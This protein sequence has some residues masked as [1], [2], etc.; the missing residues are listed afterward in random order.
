MS[1]S[2]AL[3][4][5][6][7]EISARLHFS[8]GEAIPSVYYAAG[9]RL[10][11]PVA[12]AIAGWR[13]GVK[14]GLIVCITVG[15]VILSHVAAG[16]AVGTTSID[17]AVICVG[18][19]FGCLA[20]RQGEMNR[21][22]EGQARE[23]RERSEALAKEVAERKQIE[24]Q[25]IMTDR[26]ASIGELVSGVAHEVNNPL[27][28]V[29]GISQLMLQKDLPDDVREDIAAVLSEAERAARVVR[30]LLTFARKHPPANLPSHVNDIIEDTLRLR[31]Y[32]QKRHGVEVVRNLDPALP[33][34]MVDYHQMQQVFFNIIINAEYF[35]VQHHN[36]GTLTITTERADGHIRTLFA[37]D[38]PG[39]PEPNLPRVFE[40][41][42]TTKEVGKGTGLG[43]SI[44][45]G[46]VSAQ[47][48]RIYVQ[49]RPGKGA[50]FVVE[51]PLSTG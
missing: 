20:G 12:A 31:A 33:K 30:D 16:F 8:A 4:C 7:P 25:M 24:A 21:I 42:F 40:P 32:E 2:A 10:L 22:L 34:V 13:L 3:L 26:L 44:C 37:D 1:L 5:Y 27:T 48:G 29:I 23:L 15:S 46:I 45:H 51:L 43:L 28:G 9:C 6:A 35:M 36:R 14:G 49:S 39:I 19:V 38:G 47:G 50:T 11:Y 41:F 17:L 18:F